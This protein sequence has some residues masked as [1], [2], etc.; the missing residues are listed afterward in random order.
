MA[1]S[2]SPDLLYALIRLDDGAVW[3]TDARDG[4]GRIG[5][6]IARASLIASPVAVSVHLESKSEA[7]DRANQTGRLINA[8][9]CLA[10]G[11]PVVIGGDF[12][13]NALGKGFERPEDEEPLF[14][15]LATAGYSWLGANDFSRWN[16][17]TALPAARLA[18]STEGFLHPLPP[19]PRQSTGT[20]V[21]FPITISSS[22]SFP[23]G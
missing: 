15:L 6:R 17:S 22:R 2:Y 1:T 23:I 11:R 10:S 12:N 18:F 16:S 8:V 19:R 5:Y 21:Q 7:K 4:Q 20:D 14:A 13:T 9:D 3:W